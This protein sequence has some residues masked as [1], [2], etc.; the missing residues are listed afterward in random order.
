MPDAEK[1]NAVKQIMS[2]VHK[3]HRAGKLDLNEHGGFIAEVKRRVRAAGLPED[4]LHDLV[5]TRQHGPANGDDEPAD[6]V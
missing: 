4:G 6:G 3:D 5:S 2:D 1:R